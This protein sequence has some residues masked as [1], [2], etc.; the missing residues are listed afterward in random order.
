MREFAQT[1]SDFTKGLRPDVNMPRNS[2]YATE[3]YN[4]RC[5]V[6]GLEVPPLIIYPIS[7]T[8]AVSWPLPQLVKIHDLTLTDTG[9]YFVNYA[10]GS[11][12]IKKVASDYSLSTMFTKASINTRFTVADFGYF[13]IWSGIGLMV[14]RQLATA[15]TSYE[16]SEITVGGVAP[17]VK[18]VCNFRGQLIAGVYILD[19]ET[20][21]GTKDNLVVWSEIGS[22][23]PAVM[24]SADYGF[25]DRA[26]S[27]S[28]G[29]AGSGTFTPLSNSDDGYWAPGT[30][31]FNT[32][33]YSAIVGELGGFSYSNFIRFQ[34]IT[35]PAGATI[36][37]AIV[38]V[39]CHG[40]SPSIT[41]CQ[42]NLYFNDVAD[43]TAPTSAAQADALALGSP[44]AWDLTSVWVTNQTYDTPSLVTIL[45]AVIDKSGW[46]SG[47]DV[48]LLMK[49]NA[50][51]TN[52][53]RFPRTYN[54]FGVTNAPK[55]IVTYTYN[56][57][58][59]TYPRTGA[60]MKPY[61][62]TSGN[63]RVGPTS[64]IHRV[65]P[66]GN[67][68]MVYCSDKI[69]Y[70]KAVSKPEPTFGIVP[71]K[72]FGIPSTFCAEGDE[73]EHLFINS[74][75]EVW[76]IGED[77]KIEY[78]GYREFIN[79]MSGTLI[80]T[81]N[82]N[83]GDYYISNGSKTYLLS[84]QGLS[85]WF[86]YPTSL[87]WEDANK[88]L[89]GPIA[90]AADVSAYMATD[91]FDFGVRALKTITVMEIGSTGQVMTSNIDFKYKVT[92]TVFTSSRFKTASNFGAVT[93]LVSGTE[94]KM[95]VK[96]ADYTKFDLDYLT[97]RYKYIDKR[98][99]RGTYATD[100]KV[101][102]RSGR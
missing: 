81:K 47:N 96:G 42:A 55:L 1:L 45:Q 3:L 46:A 70:M 43:A 79:A 64:T 78:L 16:W 2:G 82:E 41:G 61:K 37:S 23:N 60:P 98:M 21:G 83:F 44:V 56:E 50:S 77:L 88:R 12:T 17:P 20:I 26:L 54:Y 68:V 87:V 48:M 25:I 7:G 5:G 52:A 76:R 91:V 57:T 73:H 34:N 94:F 62:R 101:L 75:K 84:L 40:Q 15:L 86:Q 93:P 31:Q 8:P 59:S 58:S 89:I 97:V 85:E 51:P 66:L 36:V 11:L 39:E 80:I 100:A 14:K 99:I 33:E 29:V 69:F 4:T 90:V 27:L 32:S 65:L 102:S 6:A 67:G 72:S 18:C 71:L 74:N 92:D 24:F 28:T 38:R 63:Y 10:S 13:Q 49:D 19:T 35:I 22:V 9:L 30:S 95:R 53:C